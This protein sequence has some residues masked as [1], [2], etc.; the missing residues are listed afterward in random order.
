[1]CDELAIVDE[2]SATVNEEIGKDE[3]AG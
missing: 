2:T 1:L 3:K